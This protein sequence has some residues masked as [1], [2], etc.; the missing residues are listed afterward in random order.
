MWWLINQ[1]NYNVV[2]LTLFSE[3]HDL[4][5]FMIHCCFKM[6]ALIRWRE[7]SVHVEYNRNITQLS[8]ANRFFSSADTR[9]LYMSGVPVSRSCERQS[10]IVLLANRVVNIVFKTHFTAECPVDLA[11]QTTWRLNINTR[12]WSERFLQS[13]IAAIDLFFFSWGFSVLCI[14]LV[15]SSI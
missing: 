2:H 11:H 6:T 4:K 12:S 3:K 7:R 15:F 14:D 9:C 10:H 8:V 13:A 1:L 5:I